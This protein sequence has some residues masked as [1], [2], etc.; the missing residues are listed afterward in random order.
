[1]ARDKEQDE[2]EGGEKAKKEKQRLTGSRADRL[3]AL[4]AAANKSYGAG[5]ME[6]AGR[7]QPLPVPRLTT[8]SLS[9][10]YGLGGGVPV[11]H[12]TIFRGAESS[13][14]TT[15]AVRLAG[16]AQELCANCYRRPPGGIEVSEDVD[17]KTGEVA[18]VGH[19]HCDCV[20]AGL[21]VPQPHFNE[22]K[23]E[24]HARVKRWMENSYE[25]FRVA[26]EDVEGT[27]DNE[28]ARKLG[29]DPDRLVLVK[30]DS[31]EGAIDIHDEL[32]RSGAVDLIVLDSLAAM[33]PSAEIEESA[34]N[35]Q[36]GL[37]ARLLNKMARKVTAARH[38][39]RS[40]Y[41]R[42]VTEIWINQERESISIKFG[43]KSVMPGG[44]GQIFTASV[45]A[46]MWASKWEKDEVDMDMKKEFQMKMGSRVRMNFKILK[47]K[48]APA[49]G[50]GGYLMG[51]SGED[52]GQVL[53]LDYTLAQAEKFGLMRKDGAKW[54]L[55]N[56]TYKSK[57]E[58][59]ARMMEP[60][61]RRALREQL[62]KLMLAA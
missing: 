22:G 39:V 53:D 11:G 5:T 27:F 29:C 23:D 8:G 9:F 34:E 25:E 13:G 55:G 3:A 12:V 4:R 45:I 37:Q 1:M 21:C 16:L 18:R 49:Q 28:W 6:L 59:V 35:W 47:N 14:K 56:E 51:V 48:T 46:Q 50:F 31:A 32:L 24:F 7:M 26:F 42:P 38:S 58:M 33:T 17:T 15:S 52:A 62:V 41:G 36:Q 54:Q 44:K 43:D 60:A 19:A 10:D 57:T 20:K 2:G 61:V 30:P 40:D